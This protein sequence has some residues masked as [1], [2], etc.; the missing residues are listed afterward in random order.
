VKKHQVI[1]GTVILLLAASVL[2]PL[3][4][5]LVQTFP[6]IRAGNV[7]GIYFLEILPVGILLA[8]AA[9]LLSLLT[10]SLLAFSFSVRPAG[11]IW[12][13]MIWP[14][15]MP[16]YFWATAWEDVFHQIIL[17]HLSVSP[18]LRYVLEMGL[19][20][21]P[22]VFLLTVTGLRSLN[23]SW[24]ESALTISSP[25][26]VRYRIVIPLLRPVLGIGFVLVFLFVLH[27]MTVATLLGIKT[28]GTEILIRFSAFYDHRMAVLQSL[29]LLSLTWLVIGP[30]LRRI[31]GRLLH[32]ASSNRHP[33][34]AYHQAS[35]WFIY[36]WLVF[37]VGIPLAILVYESFR[38]G[39][40]GPAEAWSLLKPVW[41]PGILMALVTA[42]LTAMIGFLT[43]LYNRWYK[44]RTNWT[45]VLFFI[46]FT[47]PP[48]TL[49]LALMLFYNRPGWDFFYESSALLILAITVRYAFIGYGLAWHALSRYAAS[50]WDAI[51]LY[52]T[53]IRDTWRYM[54]LP[55]LTRD[56]LVT[57]AVV[58]ILSLGE[59]TLAFMIYPPGMDLISLKIFTLSANSPSYLV[60]SMNL[61][62]MLLMLIP[63][64]LLWLMAAFLSQK[65]KS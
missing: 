41:L 43:A 7:S 51:R 52:Q 27:D 45:A 50:M 13:L 33:T 49:G 46:L 31:T 4:Y 40:K 5:L 34:P 6:D 39:W 22:L 10:G 23:T 32:S 59:V 21:T 1:Y 28:P 42:W 29:V 8:A 48:V 9:A 60:A 17:P 64:Y 11:W 61:L 18:Y 35:P 37:G 2:V 14:L 16:A 47:I 57:M 25:S 15:L 38:Y 44:T 19:I 26:R 62:S 58:F 30:H 55:L 53:H 63:A 36:I 24:V 54:I 65:T 56:F 20:Y 3:G 12:V